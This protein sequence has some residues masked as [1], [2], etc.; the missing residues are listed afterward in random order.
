MV[1]V[2]HWHESAMEL[3][4]FPIPIP[5]PTS[6]STPSIWVF[7][8]H[9]ARALVSCIQPG[10]VICF[11]LD[12]IQSPPAPQFASI[13]SSALSFLYGPTLISIY[14]DWKNQIAL[15][16]WT[17]VSKA[18]SLLFKT[19]AFLPRNKHLLISWL[20]WPCTVILE[21]KKIRSVTVSTFS[22]CHEVMELDATN[23]F[24]F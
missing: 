18:M 14:N 4:V 5:P 19:L 10:L 11:T 8:M 3:H 21:P 20:Q 2:I 17:F 24:F 12:N 1:F 9:Q 13:N 6:L 7:P 22:L 16:I 23:L 15:T